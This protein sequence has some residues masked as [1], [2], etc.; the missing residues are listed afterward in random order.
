MKN[1]SVK[2]NIVNI[3]MRLNIEYKEISHGPVY[4]MEEAENECNHTDKEGIKTLALRTEKGEI[5]LS[6]LRGDH[7]LDFKKSSGVLGEHIKM[8]DPEDLKKMNVE[9]G[10]L[11]PFGYD[12]PLSVLYDSTIAEIEYVYINPGVNNKTFKLKSID[13][14]KAIGTWAKKVTPFCI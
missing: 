13:L 14:L 2:N 4:T 8:A 11:A 7:R 12:T 9:I 5:I 10:G 1:K 3:F 6:I